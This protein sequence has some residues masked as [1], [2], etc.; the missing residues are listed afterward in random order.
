MASYI[1]EILEGSPRPTGIEEGLSL[2]SAPKPLTHAQ[3]QDLYRGYKTN[4]S[5]N[6][7]PAF[8]DLSEQDL[9]RG[10][11]NFE[12]DYSAAKANVSELRGANTYRKELYEDFV[13]TSLKPYYAEFMGNP[14]GFDPDYDDPQQY[15]DEMLSKGKALNAQR[16]DTGLF[17]GKTDEAEKAES[18]LASPTYNK[19]RLVKE[20]FER[21]KNDF[22]RSG[23]AYAKAEELREKMRINKLAL[24]EHFRKAAEDW[25][26][27][28]P[29][30]LSPLS[31]RELNTMLDA[32]PFEDPVY[33]PMGA[34]SNI[35]KV[36]PRKKIREDMTPTGMTTGKR[37]KQQKARLERYRNQEIKKIGQQIKLRDQ[38]EKARKAGWL[39]GEGGYFGGYPLY[40]SEQEREIMDVDK[41]RKLNLTHYKGVPV[42]EAF[43]SLG[44]DESLHVAEMMESL[45]KSYGVYENTQLELARSSGS[46]KRKKFLKKSQIAEKAF[47]KAMQGA[48][49][50]GLTREVM[51]RAD[52]PYFFKATRDAWNRGDLMEDV[53]KFSGMLAAGMDLPSDTIEDIIGAM[54]A[55]EKVPKSSAY[56]S[57]TKDGP[58]ENGWEAF[59]NL[60]TNPS[61]AWDIGVESLAAFG[62]A[63]FT[64]GKYVIPGA[65]AAGAI[66]GG[67]ALG[68]PGAVGGA[69]GYAGYG[70]IANAGVASF[71]LEYAADIV[72]GMEEMGLDWRNPKVFEAAW[73]N[74]NIQA[75]LR[76]K[77]GKKAGTIALFDTLAAGT[78]GRM[79][80]IGRKVV[81][82]EGLKE[83]GRGLKTGIAKHKGVG[84]KW[85]AMKSKLSDWDDELVKNTFRQRVG[86]TSVEAAWAM[87]L[88]GTGEG[89]GQLWRDPGEKVDWDAVAAEMVAEVVGPSSV[90]VVSQLLGPK[91]VPF[92]NW[93]DITKMPRNQVGETRR[94]VKTQGIDTAG[95]TVELLADEK[96]YVQGGHKY[97]VATFEDAEQTAMYLAAHPKLKTK[98]ED[99]PMLA[100]VLGLAQSPAAPYAP[101]VSAP[102]EVSPEFGVPLPLPPHKTNVSVVLSHR[103]PQGFKNQRGHFVPDHEGGPV[104]FFNTSKINKGDPAMVVVHEASH[105]ITPAVV[106]HKTLMGLWSSLSEEQQKDA[107]A[108]YVTDS[109]KLFEELGWIKKNDVL[110]QMDKSRRQWGNDTGLAMEWVAY[111]IV[112]ILLGKGTVSVTP[113][114]KKVIKHFSK[115]FKDVTEDTLKEWATQTGVVD[116]SLPR[117]E[118]TERLIR[119]M[120]PTTIITDDGPVK[121]S[122]A[123]D[124][125]Q[126]EMDLG[127]ELG[128][129]PWLPS[130]VGGELPEDFI[131][132]QD[133][134]ALAKTPE[135]EEALN[136]LLNM[137]FPGEN[138]KWKTL[139]P[140]IKEEL[141]EEWGGRTQYAETSEIDK[142]IERFAENLGKPEARR[143]LGESATGD[144]AKTPL[145]EEPE[146]KPAPDEQMEMDLGSEAGERGPQVPGITG[147]KPEDIP[148][149]PY[150]IEDNPTGDHPNQKKLTSEDGYVTYEPRADGVAITWIQGSETKKGAGKKLLTQ[151]LE[152]HPIVYSDSDPRGG[153]SLPFLKMLRDME[154]SGEIVLER[155]RDMRSRVNRAFSIY[156]KKTGKQI[157]KPGRIEKR[158]T[159]ERMQ[160]V[161]AY[162]ITE[163]L[164]SEAGARGPQ[165]PGLR[166][167]AEEEEEAA[168]QQMERRRMEEEGVKPEKKVVKAEAAYSDELEFSDSQFLRDK[169]YGEDTWINVETGQPTEFILYRGHGRKDKE[170]VYTGKVFAPVLGNLTP[171]RGKGAYYGVSE[172]EVAQFGP[173]IEKRKVILNNPYVV[174]SGRD[175]NALIKGPHHSDKELGLN[176]FSRWNR[177]NSRNEAIYGKGARQDGGESTLDILKEFREEVQKRG[178]DGIVVRVGTLSARADN[179]LSTFGQS[180]VVLFEGAEGSKGKAAAPGTAGGVLQRKIPKPEPEEK[181]EP[182]PKMGVKER[183]NYVKILRK[184]A[185]DDPQNVLSLIA[186]I[187]V[188]YRKFETPIPSIAKLLDIPEPSVS[189]MVRSFSTGELKKFIPT[190]PDRLPS[191]IGNEIENLYARYE[192]GFDA[193]Q[194]KWPSDIQTKFENEKQEIIEK[195]REKVLQSEGIT[196]AAPAPAPAPAAKPATPVTGRLSRQSVEKDSDY[197]YIFTDNTDR[198]S[199]TGVVDPDSRYAKRY[200]GGKELH[201]P[202]QTLAVMRGLDNAFPISTMKRYR[203][204][205]P[206]KES[207][208]KPGDKDLFIK[209]IDAEIADI[210]AELSNFSGLKYS[211]SQE[212]DRKIGQGA[213]SK[214]PQELQTYLDEKL[215]EI[216]IDQRAAPA[217]APAPAAAKLMDFREDPSAG[218]YARTRKN[219]SA[220]ATVALA[221]NFKSRGEQLTKQM[222]DE[223]GK[224]YI[225]VD[226]GVTKLPGI[227]TAIVKK[228]NA[229][230][231]KT[232][233]IAG[234]GIYTFGEAYTQEQVDE[235]VYDFVRDVVNH[236]ELDNRIESIR[237][238]GQTGVDEAGAKAGIR[239]GIP[240]TVL[241]PKGWKFRPEDGK[242]VSNERAFKARFRDVAYES[243]YREPDVAGEPIDMELRRPDLGA[244]AGKKMPK[245]SRPE[246]DLEERIKKLEKQK[247]D[248]RKKLD[249]ED[250]AKKEAQMTDLHEVV[251]KS[252]DLKVKLNKLRSKAGK[253]EKTL[254]FKATVGP[255]GYSE[256]SVE[257]DGK[258]SA[259]Y[260]PKQHVALE[261]LIISME[262]NLAELEKSVLIDATWVERYTVLEEGELRITSLPL[263]GFIHP[264]ARRKAAKANKLLKSINEKRKR[265]KKLERLSKK[266]LEKRRVEVS[267]KEKGRASKFLTKLKEITE[268]TRPKWLIDRLSALRKKLKPESVRELSGRALA[269][270]KLRLFKKEIPSDWESL[271]DKEKREINKKFYEEFDLLE[272]SDENYLSAMR[273][274][275]WKKEET[276][277]FG[278]PFVLPSVFERDPKRYEDRGYVKADNRD[279]AVDN[280][281]KWL[282][283]EDFEEVQTERRDWI[284]SQIEDGS[285][286]GKTFLYAIETNERTH[287][288]ALIK[289]I[290]ENISPEKE[291]YRRKKDVN[292]R[293]LSAKKLGIL[294]KNIEKLLL[295]GPVRGPLEVHEWASIL[296]NRGIETT[297]LLGASKGAMRAALTLHSLG[298][299]LVSIKDRSYAG[300]LDLSKESLKEN[301]RF[302]RAVLPFVTHNPKPSKKQPKN[303]NSTS[304]DSAL[305]SLFESVFGDASPSFREMVSVAFRQEWKRSGNVDNT[306]ASYLPDPFFVVPEFDTPGKVR[307]GLMKTEIVK[308]EIVSDLD[309]AI[310]FVE[311]LENEVDEKGNSKAVTQ[312]ELIKFFGVGSLKELRELRRA[313]IGIH[314][315][316]EIVTNPATGESIPWQEY[317]F[318]YGRVGESVVY[319]FVKMDPEASTRPEDLDPG[320]RKLPDNRWV[321]IRGLEDR[322]PTKIDIGDKDVFLKIRN[323]MGTSKNRKS[324]TINMDPDNL[325][326]WQSLFGEETKPVEGVYNIGTKGEAR[327]FVKITSGKEGEATLDQIF[328]S[329]MNKGDSWTMGDV[330]RTMYKQKLKDKRAT[331]KPLIKL[332]AAGEV[333][334][335]VDYTPDL[336]WELERAMLGWQKDED[337]FIEPT[338]DTNTIAMLAA[339]F[340]V[341]PPGAFSLNSTNLG[342]RKWR[343]GEAPAGL[344]SFGFSHL[345]F[346][347]LEGHAP[348]NLNDE[349]GFHNLLRRAGTGTG[350]H[351]NSETGVRELRKRDSEKEVVAELETPISPEQQAR[352]EEL[353]TLSLS[354]A[355]MKEGT[356]EF[357]NTVKRIKELE[358]KGLGGSLGSEAGGTN[359]IEAFLK[360]HPKF[361]EELENFKEKYLI[362]GSDKKIDPDKAKGAAS[363][364]KDTHPG[365]SDME[366]VKIMAGSL[367]D[368]M[369]DL[370]DTATSET[371]ASIA[372]G[373][374]EDS[375]HFLEEHEGAGAHFNE[376]Y[377]N[378][379]AALAEYFGLYETAQAHQEAGKWTEDVSTEPGRPPPKAGKPNDL[380]AN[381]HPSNARKRERHTEEPDRY[382]TDTSTPSLA[383]QK[384][385]VR[386]LWPV[387]KMLQ[388]AAASADFIGRLSNYT[389]FLTREDNFRE[390]PA[391][392]KRDLKMYKGL[393]IKAKERAAKTPE[394]QG[395]SKVLRAVRRLESIIS[396]LSANI[397]GYYAN[398]GKWKLHIENEKKELGLKGSLVIPKATES[399][400]ASIRLEIKRFEELKKI[401][402]FEEH[403]TPL[404]K[405]H[406]TMIERLDKALAS[407]RKDL[408]KA[409]V[410]NDGVNKALHHL[411]DA[412]AFVMGRPKSEYSRMVEG[413]NPK[414]LDYTE[415]S[416]SDVVRNL[417]E[418]GVMSQHYTSGPNK[419]KG[420]GISDLPGSLGN[421]WLMTILTWQ[422]EISS[423]TRISE[424][425]PL[426]DEDRPQEETFENLI[427]DFRKVTYAE[428]TKPNE[429][430]VTS[431][432][433]LDEILKYMDE[434]M[435]E[436][437]HR[438]AMERSMEKGYS[439]TLAG[440]DPAIG[441]GLAVVKVK[442]MSEARRKAA[443]KKSGS[444]LVAYVNHQM[445]A[446]A[447]KLVDVDAST[448]HEDPKT[449]YVSYS[450]DGGY[451]GDISVEPDMKTRKQISE[452]AMRSKLLYIARYAVNLGLV[453]SM[454]LRWT[455]VTPDGVPLSDLKEEAFGEPIAPA[456]LEGMSADQLE[457]HMRGEGHTSEFSAQQARD[458]SA[459]RTMQRE[460]DKSRD[461]TSHAPDA[462]I[463]EILSSP[464]LSIRK[465]GFDGKTLEE[466]LDETFLSY[467]E[468]YIDR[469]DMSYVLERG[470]YSLVDGKVYKVKPATE[471]YPGS[472]TLAPDMSS[473]L[474]KSR[475]NRIKKDLVSQMVIEWKKLSLSQ[476]KADLEKRLGEKPGAFDFTDG[477][478]DHSIGFGSDPGSRY[479]QYAYLTSDAYTS[480]VDKLRSAFHAKYKDLDEKYDLQKRF[481]N[482]TFEALINQFL[483][484]EQFVTRVVKSLGI[485]R[486]HPFIQALDLYARNLAYYGVG[487][488]RVRTAKEKFHTE[489]A[490]LLA[491]YDV[492]PKEFGLWT[493]FNAVP[494]RNR[495]G[496][497]KLREALEFVRV[498]I[499]KTIGSYVHGRKDEKTFKSDRKESYTKD[500]DDTLGLMAEEEERLVDMKNN[501]SEL[502]DED[503]KELFGK[504]L[505]PENPP[506]DKD[507]LDKINEKIKNIGNKRNHLK[508]L[509]D[510]AYEVDPDNFIRDGQVSTSG[511]STKR[512]IKEIET[513]VTSDPRYQA[514]KE[515]G[516]FKLYY[517]MNMDTLFHTWNSHQA[518]LEHVVRMALANT[519]MSYERPE[520]G[521]FDRLEYALKKLSPLVEAGILENKKGLEGDAARKAVAKLTA[522]FAVKGVPSSQ[523]RNQNNDLIFWVAL[524]ESRNTSVD[525]GKKIEIKDDEGT[526]V[527]GEYD[528]VVDEN[529]W[530]KTL[531]VLNSEAYGLNEKSAKAHTEEVRKGFYEG[532]QYTPFVG[533]LGDMSESERSRP[534]MEMLG[535][536]EGSMGK[537]LSASKKKAR[538]A[539]G[540]KAKTKEGKEIEPPDPERSLAQAMVAHSEAILWSAQAEPRAQFVDMYYLFEAMDK[541]GFD[542][543]LE[544]K[545]TREDV[546][547]SDL[548]AFDEKWRKKLDVH[549]DAFRTYL[550]D[551]VE[552]DAWSEWFSGDMDQQDSLIQ[553]ESFYKIHT[554]FDRIFEIPD[555][556]SRVTYVEK[557][558]STENSAGESVPGMPRLLLRKTMVDPSKKT[559]YVFDHMRYGKHVPIYFNK[560][561]SEGLRFVQAL[562]NAKYEPIGPL[563]KII[564]PITKLMA[565]TFTSW[566]IDFMLSNLFKDAGGG[567]LN[568][569][570]D[571]KKAFAKRVVNLKYL[572]KVGYAVYQDEKSRKGLAK[573]DTRGDK[574]LAVDFENNREKYLGASGDWK[575][576]DLE[577]MVVLAA[578]QGAKTGFFK[579]YTELDYIQEM[580]KLTKPAKFPN[581]LS[582]DYWPSDWGGGRS[583]WLSGTNPSFAAKQIKR[584]GTFVD[585]ANTGVE[586]ATRTIAFIEALRLKKNGEYVFSMQDAVE[587]ARNVSVDFNKKGNL[588]TKLGS[589]Y[590]FINAGIQGN[591]RVL[592][593]INNREGNAGLHLIL[594]IMSLGATHSM[595]QRMMA[596]RAEDEED[597]SRY[598]DLGRWER[599]SNIVILTPWTGEKRVKIPIP[600]GYSIFWAFGQRVGDMLM[601]AAGPI[602]SAMSL[603]ENINNQ[604]NPWGGGTIPLIPSAFEPLAQGYMNKKFYGAPIERED[605]HFGAPTPSAYKSL[606]STKSFYRELSLIVNSAMGGDS[607]TPGSLRNFLHMAGLTDKSKLDYPYE[608]DIEWFL[609]GSMIE[610]YVH[611]YLAGPVKLL[612]SLTGG[613]YSLVSGDLSSLSSRDAPVLRRFYASEVSDWVTS[614]RFHDLRKR[615]LAANEYVKNLKRGRNPEASR[616]GMLEHRSLLKAKMFVDKAEALR[617]DLLRE[618]NKVRMSKIA[619]YKKRELYQKYKQQRI[620]ATRQAIAKARQL[621]LDV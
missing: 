229:K 168:Q 227:V 280:F 102:S 339:Y 490:N 606:P 21:L 199:G 268:D 535:E 453:P 473:E 448:M 597:R 238:G 618:E 378:T 247:A 582:R 11:Q 12:E 488:D 112:R 165:V 351:R 111:E 108:A 462:G 276:R 36:D 544:W 92:Q 178:H 370:V 253:P 195:W 532:Y 236:P 120:D 22:G 471:S 375:V 35:H 176:N 431:S 392:Y 326:L 454:D 62:N 425:A 301:E 451:F 409:V 59:W 574:A 334:I 179:I 40:V 50:M 404:S 539:L 205:V 407:R 607:V 86:H 588:G 188:L 242:D 324:F 345:L 302:T 26:D 450:K 149:K 406:K 583:N 182:A 319:D 545:K 593:A 158:I 239:L 246:A 70:L 289:L 198:D 119:L 373:M 232:L 15:M 446:I 341:I 81:S 560:N 3:E 243:M 396:G 376:F 519:R 527:E 28:R 374:G 349:T 620:K 447:E 360:K 478:M 552:G 94:K 71:M 457:E 480:F 487:S 212:K 250:P 390:L 251:V 274:P 399:D 271:T 443:V 449:G 42:E 221:V 613:A 556:D 132:E 30:T 316:I 489:L 126:M 169:E 400:I 540:R 272:A 572:A 231:V 87:G 565:R 505:D 567:F 611:G 223:Q 72:H 525:V 418:M 581:P 361:V 529:E 383:L 79:A 524:L 377:T 371:F 619:D 408:K 124:D 382:A 523:E 52:K 363:L 306:I 483:P 355:G 477:H 530:K 201:F 526:G 436:P 144:F 266:A 234:N 171:Q 83:V 452:W 194:S 74:P 147:E 379:V 533:Y 550:S 362:E 143:L 220:D 240:T 2:G 458:I 603:A 88:G 614:K 542:D 467:A 327:V 296:K 125:V 46:A 51:E 537:G 463:H 331:N 309:D 605:F 430:T 461:S 136:I 344:E 116:G 14:E 335:I 555:K 297:E 293:V 466:A 44:G 123:E 98:P 262:E 435:F 465:K 41:A 484:H 282:R 13:N 265:L 174:D 571:E 444:V 65:A 558:V 162:K 67:M 325:E 513:L 121:R 440:Q 49:S 504:K 388:F 515:N 183:D 308:K 403:T 429:V 117:R 89:L 299:S 167:V 604:L 394:N 273:P 33:D 216:G 587:I 101:D 45:W 333:Q 105:L 292:R 294:R 1:D 601:G 590:V 175:V 20:K 208:W 61:A 24:P 342:K 192:A 283:K 217:A 34:I 190:D 254:P 531:E 261:K 82:T 402:F 559:E 151:L 387:R 414:Q 338:T 509:G 340:S 579:Q 156:N 6:L 96:D 432:T 348:A 528:P 609:S 37:A 547:L 470:G 209:T 155:Q 63:F 68:G 53:G 405:A 130:N 146:Q 186:G 57:I 106:P 180:Q 497:A 114:M 591:A 214:L 419:G 48:A 413:R 496:E 31:D 336:R 249:F 222:A 343:L 207:Q 312:D 393:L 10:Y 93:G 469:S 397:E 75:H 313:F 78:T 47:I 520:G 163:G 459:R 580:D 410:D 311:G 226:F 113:E 104:M 455:G 25:K 219:A 8:N 502:T 553:F 29:E 307:E 510:Q 472:I 138:K 170:S 546:P 442:G 90:G 573:R 91:F 203:K 19:L 60:F 141:I 557:L 187:F 298:Y 291:R 97:T 494:L 521:K 159:G 16:G 140:K 142:K 275:V 599:D 541:M 575:D 456:D 43:E 427:R 621:G 54:E 416:I 277:H 330:V 517:D 204:G 270:A 479:T 228:F 499:D 258:T 202:G 577:F 356:K 534:V 358:R 589:L 17:G 305:N 134:E 95:N 538:A 233:N 267:K 576:T 578:T 197:M 426:P 115:D 58:S 244:E 133:L 493:Q 218:Y 584:L 395:K 506:T 122:I 213:I 245:V 99:I 152:E 536:N 161:H 365:V 181:P 549:R 347:M 369:R 561:S 612:E 328:A 185:T 177:A 157:L 131:K 139:D 285:L 423:N 468:M 256:L 103:T 73:H 290:N 300:G 570:E 563:L 264:A 445:E 548:P 164:G 359:I 66:K 80:A 512:A 415:F 384:S 322:P 135:G 211:L 610:H 315:N 7:P 314:G 437:A 100:K 482:P 184:Q 23:E 225:P 551:F 491:E 566:N 150:T 585:S 389:S 9:Y 310:S 368:N 215:L 148:S 460:V 329:E 508:K 441:S 64:T 616:Q 172:K 422:D 284:I 428:S 357:E 420:G 381:F 320:I 352:Q 421:G 166:A 398:E 137:V 485:S 564:N 109:G 372:I 543:F 385:R 386:N 55:L 259:G 107:V 18:F 281:V 492:S 278:N 391:R 554:E 173:K 210:K 500:L 287:A 503:L 495:V 288:K 412:R 295:Q 354:L 237:T 241:A 224:L 586:N 4:L 366:A 118:I 464:Q 193:E 269:K 32:V 260:T 304:I 602:E 417:W 286:A 600:W 303:K 475:F 153:M 248:I 84:P 562:K 38:H 501:T 595:M 411:F 191:D 127:S 350:Y 39:F 279:A 337:P 332:N 110:A 85:K 507:L 511:Y 318:D 439:V 401:A 516:V 594:S 380:N 323:G 27:E 128:R 76:K 433:L 608:D 518:G 367:M 206:V 481:V 56:E 592:K 596:P 200:S 235:I 598:D 252:R 346:R 486:R 424:L 569:S 438:K 522:E 160:A 474:L 353:H 615:T 230:N 5:A 77:S 263:Q 145:P 129:K 321:K 498:E 255:E 617:K 317:T 364:L 154:A 568:L 189:D 434:E 514:L 69:L 257:S 196:P 476:K